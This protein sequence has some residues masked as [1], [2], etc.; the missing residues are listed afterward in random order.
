MLLGEEFLVFLLWGHEHRGGHFKGGSKGE[1][2]VGQ[3]IQHPAEGR[4]LM[5]ISETAQVSV[6]MHSPWGGART[7]NYIASNYAY[8]PSGRAGFFSRT[9][10][11]NRYCR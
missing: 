7:S 1:E 8:L 3:K 2:P 9:L 6:Q 4:Q 5:Y 10:A 11:K